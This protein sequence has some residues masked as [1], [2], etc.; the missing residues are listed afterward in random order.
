MLTAS[1]SFAYGANE[2]MPYQETGKAG[3]Q[4]SFSAAT[5]KSTENT[6]HSYSHLFG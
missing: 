4:T 5:K 1:N 2:E 6:V 3:H